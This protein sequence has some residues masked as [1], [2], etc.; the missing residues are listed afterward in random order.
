MASGSDN[1]VVMISIPLLRPIFGHHLYYPLS[2]WLGRFSWRL[3]PHVDER[4]AQE[5]FAS[6]VLT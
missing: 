2:L 1:L 5:A 4:L 6:R 3:Q